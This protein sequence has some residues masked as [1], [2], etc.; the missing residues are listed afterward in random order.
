[1]QLDELVR[2]ALT[3]RRGRG[4]VHSD[5]DGSE[6]VPSLRP[7]RCSLRPRQARLRHSPRRHRVKKGRVVRAERIYAVCNGEVGSDHPLRGSDC[8]I[9][10]HGSICGSPSG[11]AR[12]SQCGPE[13][14]WL[15]NCASAAH[16][17]RRRPKRESIQPALD[18]LG[19]VGRSFPGPH[20][21]L[22]A[23]R[24]LL[25]K[26]GRDRDARISHRPVHRRRTSSLHTPANPSGQEAGRSPKWLVPLG[27]LAQHLLGPAEAAVSTAPM[28]LAG[29][30]QVRSPI[31]RRGAASPSRSCRGRQERERQARRQAQAADGE[32]PHP[33]P[34][35]L[36]DRPAGDG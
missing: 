33:A 21:D 25:R 24:R 15:G 32:E 11:R 5:V 35:I 29:P 8:G 31:Q 27:R 13:R 26:A 18:R 3:E 28:R 16:R 36:N 10:N 2:T 19:H 22:H 14:S 30:A 23:T 9:G 20:M 1:M 12:E 17:Q 7:P 34:A 6:N 4:K